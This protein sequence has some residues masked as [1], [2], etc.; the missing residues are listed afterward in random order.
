MS[1]V[2]A[3]PGDPVFFMHHG[4]VDHTWHIW[5][6][7]DPGNRLYQIS[8]NTIDGRPVTLDTVLS[9]NG[10]RPDVRV[11]DMMDIMGGYLCYRYDY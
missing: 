4:F 5:Q 8:G 6:N 10:L 1:D 7:A 2:V 9:S 11:G 3:S